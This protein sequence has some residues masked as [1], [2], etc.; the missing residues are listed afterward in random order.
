[1]AI[2]LGSSIALV[3]ALVAAP[4]PSPA[5]AIER[6]NEGVALAKRFETAEA[7]QALRDAIRLDPELAHAWLN[8]G[9]LQLRTQR[10]DAAAISFREGLAVASG[11]IATE[12]HLQLGLLLHA[13]ARG[14][15]T[16]A[17]RDATLEAALEHLHAAA[18][19]EPELAFLHAKIGEAHE[20]LDQPAEADAAYRRAIAAD[21][22]FVPAFVALGILYIDYGYENL[23]VAVLEVCTQLN[24]G[25]A[26]SFAGLGRGMAKRGRHREAI[27]AFERALQLDPRN[28]ELLFRLGM[29][30]AELRERSEA[31][32]R[33]STFL[34]RAGSE[35]SEDMLRLAR[36]TIAR[37]QDVI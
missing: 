24:D 23:G 17:R 37:M 33:L 13:A 30:H 8:L 4:E 14:Q 6:M 11:A 15:E 16:A 2:V 22:S 3:L 35:T 36:D 25:D 27:E 32:E 1:M 28:H 7:E 26:G 20:Q 29:S 9:H 10:P 21:P 5:R 31:I 19:S 34:E 18:R 12:L